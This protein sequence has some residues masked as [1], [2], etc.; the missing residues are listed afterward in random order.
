MCYPCPRTVLLPFSP[1]RTPAPAHMTMNRRSGGQRPRPT[2]FSA[3]ILEHVRA[4]GAS[5]PAIDETA[6]QMRPFKGRRL[7]PSCGTAVVTTDGVRSGHAVSRPRRYDGR[8]HL[9]I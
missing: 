9:L 8:R 5:Q 4:S 6:P 1:D 7:P 3:Y 2:V